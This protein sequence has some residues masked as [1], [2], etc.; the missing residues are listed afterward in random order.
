VCWPAAPGCPT[1]PGLWSSSRSAAQNGKP[2]AG[3][4][5]SILRASSLATSMLEP[6]SSSTHRAACFY[7]RST[8]CWP[9]R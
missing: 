7:S 5:G 8:K 1:P 9:Q 2:L 3:Q 4:D 6:G